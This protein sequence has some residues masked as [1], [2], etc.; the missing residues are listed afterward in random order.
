MGT[1]A[2]REGSAEAE[3]NGCPGTSDH[4]CSLGIDR[5]MGALFF[6]LRVGDARKARLDELTPM[7]RVRH[8]GR[9]ELPERPSHTGS[10]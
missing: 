3:R 5:N 4:A 7:R 9:G 2:K 1:P 8:G 10:K 6:G